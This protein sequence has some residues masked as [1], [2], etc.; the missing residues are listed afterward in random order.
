MDSSN[1]GALPSNAI[2]PILSR[3]AQGGV[4]ALKDLNELDEALLQTVIDKVKFQASKE[5][6][7]AKGI[8]IKSIIDTK[9]A[10]L[11]S[12]TADIAALKVDPN[13]KTDAQLQN[14]KFGLD[15]V[16]QLTAA[17][18]KTA[19]TENSDAKFCP[20]CLVAPKQ[21]FRCAEMSCEGNWF[22]STC[23]EDL[24]LCPGCRLEFKTNPP[25]RDLGIERALARF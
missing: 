15:Q 25:R 19:T 23:A 22:C 20:I 8:K 13:Y 1:G 10:N 12:L 24:K 6:I 5:E 18:Q 3:F 9:E 16:A 14:I 7:Y 11:K 2:S 17:F 4:E 21:I